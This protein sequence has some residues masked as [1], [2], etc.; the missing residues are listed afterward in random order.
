MKKLL[1][2]FSFLAT[3]LS[4]FSLAVSAHAASICPTG[5]FVNLCKIS[6]T[7]NDRL[8][9]NIITIMLIFG[10]IIALFFLIYGGIRWITSGGDKAKVEAARGTISAAIVGLLLAFLAF[11]FVNLIL[12]L[13]TGKPIGRFVIPTLF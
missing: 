7:S 1:S 5:Q 12:V 8:V 10:V 9:S 3:S 2:L 4:Y 6:L 11:F 13:L